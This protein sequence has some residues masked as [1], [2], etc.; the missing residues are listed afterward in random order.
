VRY[1]RI[2]IDVGLV[3]I[4]LVLISYLI[5][6]LIKKYVISSNEYLFKYAEQQQGTLESDLIF[7]HLINKSSNNS[8][9]YYERS[10]AFNKRGMFS[11]GLLFLNKAVELDPIIYLGYR[12]W[13]KLYKLRD[14]AGA[15]DDFSFLDSLTSNH[16][17]YPMSENIHFLKAICLYNLGKSQLSIEQFKEATRTSVDG[18]QDYKVK[19]YQGI[20]DYNIGEIESAITLLNEA[21]EIHPKCTEAYFYLSKIYV[22]KNTALA[23]RYANN[24]KKFYLMGYTLKDVY[25][26]LPFEVYIEDIDQLFF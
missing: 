21:I 13:I 6:P 19:L 14:Y 2:I 1:S 25:N 9:Y 26:E 24:A 12:G 18:F 4:K 8:R 7:S 3:I 16:V 5:F 11:K 15:L 17:D 20:V 22:N 10:V 23:N